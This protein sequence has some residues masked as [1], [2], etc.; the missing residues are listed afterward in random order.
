LVNPDLNFSA[1]AYL[2]AQDPWGNL[3]RSVNVTLPP[4]TKMVGLVTDLFNLSA[5]V[6]GWVEGWADRAIVGLEVIHANDAL[7]EAWGVAGIASQPVGYDIY[8][9]H[10][11]VRSRWWTMFALANPNDA[12]VITPTVNAYSNGGLLMTTVTPAIN[13]N[14]M[15]AQQVETFFGIP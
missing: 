13:P 11:D 14:G 1:N 3:L 5:P 12:L 7:E 6:Q 15:L 8:Y 10:F 2:Y 9:T 4:R